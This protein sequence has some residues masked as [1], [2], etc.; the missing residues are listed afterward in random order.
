MADL[1][2][3]VCAIAIEAGQTI[4]ALRDSSLAAVQF[5]TD[6]SPVTEADL[7]A[8][9]L[10][11][12]RLHDLAVA[13]VI[14]EEGDI[15]ALSGDKFWLVDPLDG[16]KDFVAG[17]K[18][19]VVNI[20]LIDKRKPVLG[21]IYAPMLDE[22]FWAASGKGAFKLVASRAPEKIFNSS[23][24]EKFRVLASGSMMTPRMEGFLNAFPVESLER[25]GSALKMARIAEGTADFYPRFGPT[26]EWDTAAGHAILNE[27]GCKVIDLQTGS[28]I[29]YGKAGFRN[30]GFV[31]SR[32]D[33]DL[34]PKIKSLMS[35]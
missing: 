28:E 7:A 25:F 23:K 3:N 12:K 8:N 21:V 22:M 14:S 34:W 32:A 2:K 26:H 33:L 29:E 24:R 35:R 31:A 11:V 13:P 4:L 16:T 9:A 30:N 1:I 17:K 6:S 27:A 19:F 15:N 20:A 5:K 18:T 10:I